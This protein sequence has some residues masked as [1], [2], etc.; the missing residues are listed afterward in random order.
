MF[1]NERA[2]KTLDTTKEGAVIT[3]IRLM[4]RWVRGHLA[5]VRVRKLKAERDA[6]LKAE[7]EAMQV[8]VWYSAVIVRVV[9]AFGL[10]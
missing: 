10:Y 2:K 6:R 9:V 7:R 1:F 5:R 3:Y 4:Q 8:Q